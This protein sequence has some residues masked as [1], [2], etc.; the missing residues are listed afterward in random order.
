[1]SAPPVSQKINKATSFSGLIFYPVSGIWELMAFVD[2]K[3]EN[4]FMLTFNAID[5]LCFFQ[6]LDNLFPF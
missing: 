1:M 5:S 4:I 3:Q 2:A 6:K